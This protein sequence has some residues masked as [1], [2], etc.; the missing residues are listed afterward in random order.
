MTVPAP[1]EV[2]AETLSAAAGQRA[3]RELLA[4]GVPFTALLTGSDILAAGCCAEL[5]VAGRPCP[6]AVSVTGTGDTPL[7][8]WLPVP[9]TTVTLPWHATGA[10][11]ARLLIDRISDPDTPA[12]AIHLTSRLIERDSTSDAAP[13]SGPW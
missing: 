10:A 8:G 1:L 5:A 2:S 13:V 7:A 3:C 6:A 11:A 12:Q 9:L 4:V